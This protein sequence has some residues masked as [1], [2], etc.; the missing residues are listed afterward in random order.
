MGSIV[1]GAL[2]L[3]GASKAEDQSYAAGN[4][5]KALGERGSAMAQFKPFGVTGSPVAAPTFQYDSSGNIIGANYGF[6]PQITSQLQGLLGNI[7]SYDT[8]A[9]NQLASQMPGAASSLFNLGSQYLG[10]SPQEV[11]QNYVKSQLGLL[12]PEF[13]QASANLRNRQFQTGRG[14]LATGGTKAGYG[15]GAPGL[16]QTNPEQAALANAYAKAVANVTANAP[17]E[18]QKQITFGAGLFDT[19]AG[20]AANAP[21]LQSASYL[22]LST[23]IQTAGNL[24]SF[25]MSPYTSSIGLGENIS[26]GG[27][28]Q[29]GLLQSPYTTGINTQLKGQQALTSAE[30]G[31]YG[32]LASSALGAFGF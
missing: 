22:P 4:E 21:K 12:Q 32:D 11:Q 5:L 27:A 1:S 3:M 24:Q 7:G 15:V 29:A 8:T 20:I 10:Q 9:Y 26:A 16:A 25:G 19:G 18:A 13:E 31:F 28:R 14:G 30:Y 2:G 23:A 17:S 6:A